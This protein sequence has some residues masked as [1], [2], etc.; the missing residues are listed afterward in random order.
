MRS[1]T[2]LVV[3]W[4]LVVPT[5]KDFITQKF[6]ECPLEISESAAQRTRHLS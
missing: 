2:S 3:A 6:L 1:K 5:R 4:H